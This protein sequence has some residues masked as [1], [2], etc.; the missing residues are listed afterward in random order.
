MFHLPPL[1]YEPTAL[2]PYLTAHTFDFHYRK[3]HQAYIDNLNKLIAGTKFEHMTLVDIVRATYGKHEYEGIFNN[4]AQALNHTIFW[5]SIKPN[6]G[7]KPSGKLLAEIEESFGSWETFRSEFRAA[8]VSLFGSGWLWL[9]RREGG[10]VGIMKTSNA[11]TP[12]A[13]ELEPI[14]N[15]D[16]WEHAYYLDYQNRRPDYVDAFLDHLVN[17]HD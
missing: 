11:D 14:L 15:I 16:V 4:A 5:S 3:H 9:I 10:G 12:I 6:G 17:W 2:E 8:A 7:G 13:H 1:P